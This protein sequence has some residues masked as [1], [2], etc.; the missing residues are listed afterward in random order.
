MV[1]FSADTAS[2]ESVVEC[3]DAWQPWFIE[4]PQRHD[5]ISREHS[6]ESIQLELLGIGEYC[7]MAEIVAVVTHF[8]DIVAGEVV[9]TMDHKIDMGEGTGTMVI[10]CCQ[11]IASPITCAICQAATYGKGC[12]P[13]DGPGWEAEAMRT[14]SAREVVD[15]DD[16]DGN[17]KE[18]K[19]SN[20]NRA[21]SILLID[22]ETMAKTPNNDRHLDQMGLVECMEGSST[23]DD[24]K[25]AVG[26]MDNRCPHLSPTKHKLLNDMVPRLQWVG[27]CPQGD[28]LQYG[29]ARPQPVYRHACW[30]KEPV[31]LGFPA[32]M[33]N[34]T[35][36][37]LLAPFFTENDVSLI[38][39]LHVGHMVCSVVTI[40]STEGLGASAFP[41]RLRET[42][43]HLFGVTDS[44][45]VFAVLLRSGVVA[46]AM[47]TVVCDWASEIWEMSGIWTAS[48]E[49]EVTSGSLT[50]SGS[51]AEKTGEEG[52]WVTYFETKS[53][54]LIDMLGSDS[55]RL[56][57]VHS[58]VI[59][60]F[61]ANIFEYCLYCENV[62]S[63]RSINILY[64]VS[65]F[66]FAISPSMLRESEASTGWSRVVLWFNLCDGLVFI[67]IISEALHSLAVS[68]LKTM[69]FLRTLTIGMNQLTSLE[70]KFN[71]MRQH[72]ASKILPAMA[73]SNKSELKSLA[74]CVAKL[75]ALDNKAHDY[76]WLPL[77]DTEPAVVEPRT[78]RQHKI[79]WE[80]VDGDED[81]LPLAAWK[82]K[83]D[84]SNLHT[85]TVCNYLQLYTS[86]FNDSTYEGFEDEQGSVVKQK[87][88]LYG[89]KQ[90]PRTWNK[91]FVYF[92]KAHGLHQLITD[93]WVFVN[94]EGTDNTEDCNGME[95]VNF[96][97]REAVTKNLGLRYSSDLNT[98]LIDTYSDADYAG[99]ETSCRSTSGYVILYMVSLVAWSTRK[100]PIISLSTAESE[101]IAT[102][103]FIPANL[104][105]DN[106][107]TIQMIKNDSMT[108]RQ[109]SDVSVLTH[110]VEITGIH[111]NY[112]QVAHNRAVSSSIMLMEMTY[113]TL[114]KWPH[115]KSIMVSRPA[116]LWA[117]K[118]NLPAQPTIHSSIIMLKL[119]VLPDIKRD[120]FSQLG[121]CFLQEYEVDVPISVWWQNVRDN[122]LTLHN[123]CTH[124]Q[125]KLLLMC[126]FVIGL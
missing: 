39:G 53:Q 86:R 61:I 75:S 47:E 26:G 60:M 51:W 76:G 90:A 18:G 58:H 85:S 36:Q 65:P 27:L 49:E 92:L 120:I 124:I 28:H 82:Y 66:N 21:E 56:D 24:D 117:M 33:I 110:A 40:T 54:S 44:A 125:V 16:D 81:D 93:K 112:L 52:S 17:D 88:S 113:T 116:M 70:W 31:C 79:L 126:T 43:G 91:R 45:I 30:L 111:C 8:P 89:L 25:E 67:G 46:T 77:L 2:C 108:K 20:E 122:K 102:S 106:Q 80:A 42:R 19:D 22:K 105:I 87:K 114:L 123:F 9:M 35:I 115:R 68:S 14:C 69:D 6:L 71:I 98:S 23:P 57:K 64:C 83:K 78:A 73:A 107:S 103:E 104:N 1:L 99:D 94:D 34:I 15:V 7:C 97:Y 4:L 3:F 109:H 37:D 95:G 62:A 100:L 101:F 121:E 59:V 63:C 13:F 5:I 84:Q 119:Y 74:G 32:C 96:P 11:C 118:W 72:I 12:G 55:D 48:T 10:G 50:M 38:Q 29:D 41:H